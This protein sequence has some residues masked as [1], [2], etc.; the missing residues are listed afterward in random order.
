M[1]HYTGM[2]TYFIQWHDK[3][4]A[5]LLWQRLAEL[6]R[7]LLHIRGSHQSLHDGEVHVLY[8]MCLSFCE[9]NFTSK[10]FCEISA[11]FLW[12]SLWTVFGRYLVLQRFILQKSAWCQCLLQCWYPFSDNMQIFW[13]TIM[14]FRMCR[15][16][17]VLMTGVSYFTYLCIPNRKTKKLFLKRD[18]IQHLFGWKDFYIKPSSLSTMA[19]IE[20]D[21]YVII[22]CVC[23]PLQWT[24]C[25]VFDG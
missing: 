12:V 14:V 8:Y 6:S 5:C 10:I 21:C 20:D 13:Q 22:F 16:P 9:R 19:T 2:Q 3:H 7:S 24:S 15:G 25:D 11:P 4:M 17:L 1:S 18:I 23:H